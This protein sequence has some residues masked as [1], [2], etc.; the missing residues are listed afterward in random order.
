[1][2]SS[3]TSGVNIS[4]IL[5]L[6][7]PSAQTLSA[8]KDQPPFDSLLQPPPSPPVA[9]PCPPAAEE[10]PT[11]R[12]DNDDS[13]RSPPPA[14]TCDE[15]EGDSPPDATDSRP[16]STSHN[17]SP[18]SGTSTKPDGDG[19]D[20]P[21]Q[22]QES[23]VV[24]VESLAGLAAAIAN[25]AANVALTGEGQE[26]PATNMGPMGE[27][28]EKELVE[29]AIAAGKQYGG[30]RQ[31]PVVQV[32]PKKPVTEAAQG[33]LS[34]QP[35]SEPSAQNLRQLAAA[36]TST[37]QHATG[38]EDVV[39]P[40]KS[41]H[42]ATALAD[43]SLGEQT[44]AAGDN[45]LTVAD[46]AQ[47]P[48]RSSHDPQHEKPQNTDPPAIK[49]DANAVASQAPD[50]TAATAANAPPAAASHAAQLP[51][52]NPASSPTS[53]T[54]ANSLANAAPAPRSRL[55]ADVLTQPANGPHR[56]TN[57][58]VDATRLLTRVARAFTAAQERDRE[59]RL[60]LSPP[61]LGSLRLDVRVQDG[62]LVARLQTE[63]DAAR[64]AILDNLPAL[65]DRL[66]EQGVRIERFDV[67]L[68]QRQPG[69]M[70]D[71]PG[72]RQQDLPTEP[73]RVVSP[74]PRPRAEAAASALPSSTFVGSAD[75]LNVI[76]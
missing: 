23:E 75:G 51:V 44:A 61:E 68:M 42:I 37:G 24:I 18:S 30:Q 67:D 60:R 22:P 55:P 36:D 4:T 46:I 10:P 71:Q 56:H 35:A 31:T 13:R 50:P 39:E 15:H 26:N 64:T 21:D 62:V 34:S 9:P 5:D 16:D 48:F 1:M 43:K 49:L 20:K 53:S 25:P 72:G 6:I 33:D 57:V 14:A 19:T 76:V 45:D 41:D 54:S 27:G 11:A 70:P 2:P 69:G 40:S 52:A 17:A 28:P 73:V 8:G 3:A 12:L 47:Q 58:E 65:R 32:A 66:S 7:G 59:I 38:Q 63:T 29:P 74:A